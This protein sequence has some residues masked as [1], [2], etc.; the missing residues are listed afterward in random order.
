[1]AITI[2]EVRVTPWEVW[3]MCSVENNFGLSPAPRESWAQP[4][5][6]GVFEDGPD[7]RECRATLCELL[8]LAQ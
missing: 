2:T 3:A 5:G 4:V 7:A 6:L 8:P 1:M